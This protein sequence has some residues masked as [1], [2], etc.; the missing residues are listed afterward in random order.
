MHLWPS[1]L[2]KSLLYLSLSRLCVIDIFSEA[3]LCCNKVFITDLCCYCCFRTSW[4]RNASV[5]AGTGYRGNWRWCTV[6]DRSKQCMSMEGRGW[7]R[8]GGVREKV[9]ER[10]K[11]YT[12]VACDE[13]SDLDGCGDAKYRVQ[14]QFK[15]RPQTASSRIDSPHQSIQTLAHFPNCNC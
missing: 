10:R 8:N 12:L 3:F 2:S 4:A 7:N 13:Q 5:L 11:E 14:A 1:Q 6:C 15:A 9:E